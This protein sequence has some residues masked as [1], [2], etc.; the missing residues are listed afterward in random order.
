[1]RITSKKVELSFIPV[2][3]QKLRD[4]GR[5][6]RMHSNKGSLKNATICMKIISFMFDLRADLDVKAY[7]NEH[8][9]T[10][11]DL[12]LRAIKCYISEKKK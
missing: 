3:I 4:F 6:H 9:G 10:L 7:L 8:G 11:L 1:M 12:I 2:R 5:E